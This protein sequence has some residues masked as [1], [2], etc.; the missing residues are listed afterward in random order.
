MTQSRALCAAG[1]LAS[2]ALFAGL[3]AYSAVPGLG[4]AI[5]DA[6]SILPV[7][8]PS[9]PLPVPAAPAPVIPAPAPAPAPAPVLAAP[10]P[11]PIVAAP[12]PPVAVP[13]APIAAP[14]APLPNPVATL[15]S[16]PAL[17]APVEAAAGA[18]AGTALPALPSVPAPSE[19]VGAAAG[20][21]GAVTGVAAGAAGALAA[22]VGE[23]VGGAANAAGAL[24]APVGEVVG[25][26]ANAAGSATGAVTQTVNG[27]LTNP[28]TVT[29]APITSGIGRTV[30]ATGLGVGLG[31]GT[32]EDV[33]GVAQNAANA[34]GGAVQ[35]VN[36]VGRPPNPAVFDVDLQGNRIVR[37]EVLALGPTAQA[38]AQAQNL[39]FTIL[40]DNPVG[41]L[42]RLI[43]F[44]APQGMNA[45]QAL[46]ALRQADPNG[47]YELNHVYD[48]SGEQPRAIPVSI[49]GGEA[50]A[51]PE[52]RSGVA[53]GLVDGGVERTHN[54][55]RK[56]NIVSSNFA[57]EGE[58]PPTAHGT[59]IASLMVGSGGVNG[60]LPGATLYVADV[61]GGREDGGAA[62]AI[63][64]GLVWTAEKGATVI[65][66][67][68][69]G[70]PNSLLETA[71]KALAAKGHVIVAAVGNDGPAKPV[72]Y[73]AAYPSVIA[74][75]SVD[76]EHNIQV[77]AN[78]GPQVLFATYGVDVRVATMNNAYGR[79][80]GTS[81]A[82]PLLAARIAAAMSRP[83]ARL[84]GEVR[85]TLQNEARDLG[86]KGR[87]PV[88]GFGFV[89]STPPTTTA[90]RQ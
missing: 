48:P 67:S 35:A 51:L 25:G 58:S 16:A 68:L 79:A 13:A 65:N 63:I 21:A 60:V 56:A 54:D 31:G 26:A 22:P 29:I 84:A 53:I 55:L 49:R 86:A 23:V 24:T 3:P 30:S 2:L 87:D 32:L 43:V 15:P 46:N 88:F 77:D 59:A 61:Y 45:L 50:T 73:P 39:N 40:Q 10:A 74:V 66:V 33:L 14:A 47:A 62:D 41:A 28:G 72:N 64:R 8:P 37:N 18:L 75:T 34:L 78:R 71:V 42:G 17:P 6:G 89:D 82:A 38:L 7:A 20:A 76:R 83:D 70:P 1:L 27:V 52:T 12:A 85:R 9:L 5:G 4:G 36:D 57:V 90:S 44:A 19:I 80:T 11:A 69:V 81:F